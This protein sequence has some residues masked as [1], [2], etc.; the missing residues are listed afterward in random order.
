MKNI[1]LAWCVPP[2]GPVL[3]RSAEDLHQPG[4]TAY[5]RF[6][7]KTV[8]CQGVWYLMVH[9]DEESNGGLH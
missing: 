1:C 9:T 2:G 7:E 6:F 4:H 3:L 8:Q 5:Y